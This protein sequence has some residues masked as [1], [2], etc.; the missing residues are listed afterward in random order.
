MVLVWVGVLPWE[1]A[2]PWV[3]VSGLEERRLELLWAGA[4]GLEEERLG[5]P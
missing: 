4:L 3:G 5:S 1:P 2:W